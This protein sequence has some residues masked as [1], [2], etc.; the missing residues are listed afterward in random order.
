[1]TSFEYNGHSVSLT[2]RFE[3]EVA[4][5][6]W[7]GPGDTHYKMFGS[8]IDAKNEIDRRV[9]QATK[10]R[11]VVRRVALPALDAKGDKIIIRGINR[12]DSSI[13][14]GSDA[15]G[16]RQIDVFPDLTWI[17][18]LLKRRHSLCAEVDKIEVAVYRF[19]IKSR[20]GYGRLAGNYDEHLQALESEFNRKAQ[21]AIQAAPKTDAAA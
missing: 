2:E 17:A 11:E 20:R 16:F 7:T 10:Q 1:M 18:D 19:G 21:E 8:A 12:T 15:K 9:I 13:L 4:G 5:P 3:F 14:G 6:E